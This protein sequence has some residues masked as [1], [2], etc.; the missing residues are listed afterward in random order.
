MNGYAKYY[1]V[2][3]GVFLISLA[4]MCWIYK[5]YFNGVIDYGTGFI[6]LLAY[7]VS[8]LFGNKYKPCTCDTCNS[9]GC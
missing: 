6:A 1:L 5:A 7:A 8:D 3:F 2:S 9:T 4:I